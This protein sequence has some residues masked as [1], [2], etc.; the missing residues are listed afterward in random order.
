MKRRYFIG[1][2]MA[3][4]LR[5]VED[6]RKRQNMKIDIYGHYFPGNTGIALQK[7]QGPI[8]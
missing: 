4:N 5:L 8:D 3:A 7:G 2:T 1:R 6:R